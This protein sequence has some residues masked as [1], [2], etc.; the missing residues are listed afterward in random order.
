MTLP[1]ADAL[2][3][4]LSR[5]RDRILATLEDVLRADERV[6]AAWLEGSFGRGTADAWSDIDL[7]VVIRD[8]A[9]ARWLEQRD[10]LYR[11]LGRPVLVMPSSASEKGDYQGVIFAG[12]VWVDLAIHPAS[13]A[14]RE[15]DTR[16][17]FDR[18]AVPVRLSA[19][20]AA[21]RRSQLRHNLEFF[22][23]MSPIALK[24][25]G[26]GRTQR[27]VTQCDLLFGSF[28]NVWRLLHD[29]ERRDAGG[30][31]WLHPERDAELI[32]LLPGFGAVI[33]PPAA[34]DVVTRLMDAMRRLHPALNDLDVAVPPEVITEIAAFR[35]EIARQLA[36]GEGPPVA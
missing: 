24:Y 9:L 27:A 17:L 26:R 11:R 5:R 34:L 10:D 4:R 6:L 21:E 30:V 32:R 33:D 29:P 1:D 25:I 22:W 7:H 18:A 3:I 8:D 36:G 31:H 14:M 28:V 2:P 15:P 13:T 20:I 35:D 23:A 19:P 16:F 12:P